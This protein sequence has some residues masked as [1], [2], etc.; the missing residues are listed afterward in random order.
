[1]LNVWTFAYYINIICQTNVQSQLV[2]TRLNDC[3]LTCM[4]N[5]AR[6][7][8]CNNTSEPIHFRLDQRRF[9]MS[10][11]HVTNLHFYA[12]PQQRFGAIW[13]FGPCWEFLPPQASWCL[14]ALW[15]P[16]FRWLF[17]CI[18]FCGLECVGH[19]FAY[20][21]HFV[22]LILRD[23]WSRTQRTGV[24]NLATHLPR[25]RHSSP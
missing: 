8:M 13:W 4:V 18:F 24:A 2:D 22:F 12:V 17:F 11:F 5:F 10:S 16:L 21:A 9:W 20:V 19:S 15:W 7:A 23:V 6:T 25:L 1:M 14:R 3:T